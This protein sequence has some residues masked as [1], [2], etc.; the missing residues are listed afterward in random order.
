M[1]EMNDALA[2]WHLETIDRFCRVAVPDFMTFAEDLS[3]NLGPM[4]SRDCFEEF[5]TPY[6][7]TSAIPW[8]IDA[9]IEGPCPWSGRPASTWRTCA[10]VSRASSS[11]AATTS[12]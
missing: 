4:I 7:R 3:Y 11:S 1:H 12:W 9:G 10:H 2:D 8:F 6:Y 5:L